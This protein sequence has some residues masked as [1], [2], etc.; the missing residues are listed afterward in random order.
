MKLSKRTIAITFIAIALFLFAIFA[1]ITQSRINRPDAVKQTDASVNN[2]SDNLEQ[3]YANYSGEAFDEQYIAGMLA[4][5]EGAVNMS[6]NAMAISKKAEIRK[7]AQDII[8]SQSM[9]MSKMV[10][11]QADWGYE[12]TYGGHASHGGGGV[13]MAGDMVEMYNK[14]KDKTGEEYD[15]EFLKQMIIHH[16]QAIE[17]SKP[18]ATNAKRYEIKQLAKEVI[19]AQESEVVMMK[20]WQEDWAY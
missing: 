16:T 14:L 3:E 8:N 19:V 20:K 12:K 13:D 11:W 4:H 18:A 6:E 5:H 17:M 10:Q 15:K 2:K 7:L 9:E 1:V